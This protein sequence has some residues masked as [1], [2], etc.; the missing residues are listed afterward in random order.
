MRTDNSVH[1]I[2]KMM[3]LKEL[4]LQENLLALEPRFSLLGVVIETL[5]KGTF[6]FR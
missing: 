5:D 1:F 2:K 4:S 3:L 6:S